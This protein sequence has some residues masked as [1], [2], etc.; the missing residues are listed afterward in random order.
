MSS[1]AMMCLPSGIVQ[2]SR[3]LGFCLPVLSPMY[4][5]TLLT[6][7][8]RVLVMACTC[9]T[10]F[11]SYPQLAVRNA[12]TWSVVGLA[13]VKFFGS[14]AGNLGASPVGAGAAGA[15]CAGAWGTS[16]G[17][18]GACSCATATNV[19]AE[20]ASARLPAI[21][22]TL[23]I[24]SFSPSFGFSRLSVRLSQLSRPGMPARQH[25]YLNLDRDGKPATHAE[26][27][28]SHFQHRRGL[29]PLVFGTFHKTNYL[30]DEIQRKSVSAR[31]L[32]RRLVA[33]HIR[34]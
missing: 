4:T 17:A 10:R 1:P 33:L 13:A 11:S 22:P 26:R 23:R 21:R 28:R 15:V 14:G 5:T 27:F 19:R 32:L 2:N 30:L 24:K 34:F 12:F 29:L 8:T 18:A 3:A 20:A 25:L 9:H 7:S 6:P 16:F 31:D